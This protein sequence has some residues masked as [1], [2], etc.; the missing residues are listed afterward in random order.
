[1]TTVRRMTGM[2]QAL[3][4]LLGLGALSPA[5]G[6]FDMTPYRP[7]NSQYRAS[8]FP[9]ELSSYGDGVMAPIYVAPRQAYR[10][11]SFEARVA[12]ELD[13]DNY[14]TSPAQGARG[15]RPVTPGGDASLNETKRLRDD[16]YFK[17][18]A[19]GDPKR[20]AE[21]MEAYHRADRKLDRE[22]S[23]RARPI[24]RASTPA[25]TRSA[26]A[27]SPRRA[28]TPPATTPAT[29]GTSAAAR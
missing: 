8:S 24:A 4:T 13:A 17:A 28:A 18:M 22:L 23:S 27:A 9:S 25:A 26:P 1:M 21:L 2:A 3:A 29:T 10:Q 7:Y 19:E 12:Q 11:Q 14:N 6:Q 15:A 20:R 5:F 16:Y